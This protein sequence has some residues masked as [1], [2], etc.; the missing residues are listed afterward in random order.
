MAVQ[1]VE[2]L[3][4]GSVFSV[5]LGLALVLALLFAAAWLVRRLQRVQPRSEGA[6]QLVAQ[7]PVGIKERLLV[8]RVG[9]ENVLIGVAPGQIRSLHVWQGGLPA[10]EPAQPVGPAF[11]DHL[12]TLMAER[13]IKP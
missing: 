7:L 6:I 8:V 1:H 11:L 10:G 12:K 13:R 9:D 4:L 5:M 3:S 2:P